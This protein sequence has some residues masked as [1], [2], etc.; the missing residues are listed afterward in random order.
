MGHHLY[1]TNL[2]S[3]PEALF[4]FSKRIQHYDGHA[5]TVS[6][7]GV[8]QH[9]HVDTVHGEGL[10]I[11]HDEQTGAFASKEHGDLFVEYHVVLP[12][13]S[14]ALRS[15]LQKAFDSATP[16]HTDL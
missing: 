3:L 16:A 8:T 13:T 4:G 6:R 7:S 11:P 9:G 5:F 10:P 1:L 14:G 12:D 2:L 15:A